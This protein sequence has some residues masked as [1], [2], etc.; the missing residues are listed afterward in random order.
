MADLNDIQAILDEVAVLGRHAIK[1]EFSSSMARHV[2]ELQTTLKQLR[3]QIASTV[4]MFDPRPGKLSWQELLQSS[5][6]LIDLLES[7]KKHEK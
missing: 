4:A 2:E 5:E 3:V 6:T 1:D 7:F